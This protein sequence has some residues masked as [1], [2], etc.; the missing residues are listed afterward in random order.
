MAKQ[1][2]KHEETRRVLV[3]L[4]PTE[5]RRRISVEDYKAEDY[6]PSEVLASLVRAH[7]GQGTG[8]LDAAVHA[9]YKRLM[10]IVACFIRRNPQWAA[11]ARRNSDIVADGTSVAWLNLISDSS[12]VCFAEIR[13][14]TFVERRTFD[15]MRHLLADKNQAEPDAGRPGPEGE[16]ARPRSE[17]VVDESEETQL[18]TAIRKQLS[19]TLNQALVGLPKSERRAVYLRIV[20]ECDWATVARML[21]C[22]VPTAR[23]H[24]NRGLE[25]L[26]GELK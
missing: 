24:M 6:I 11:L 2:P 22:S 15:Y 26:R 3:G 7:F 8:V 17:S 19:V 5:I 14:L 21:R 13:F 16:E 20:Q 4:D 12:A 9:L 25:K 23:Q 10:V 18:E 1:D